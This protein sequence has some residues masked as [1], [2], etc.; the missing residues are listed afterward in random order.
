MDLVSDGQRSKIS[1]DETRAKTTRRKAMTKPSGTAKSEKSGSGKPSSKTEGE[2]FSSA[3]SSLL[4]AI[5]LSLPV[6]AP[7]TLTLKITEKIME[8]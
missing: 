5:F 3:V 6:P 4:V 1:E 2:R 8:R 7:E